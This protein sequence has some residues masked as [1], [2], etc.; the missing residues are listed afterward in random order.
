VIAGPLALT[1]PLIVKTN[2]E[3]NARPAKARAR[4]KLADEP[5]S[6]AGPP[7]GAGAPPG[8]RRPPAAGCQQ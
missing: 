8:A 4:P 2:P 6:G 3:M 5:P 1:I 7:P